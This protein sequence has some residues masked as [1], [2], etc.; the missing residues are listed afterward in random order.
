MSL[1]TLSPQ[2]SAV[3]RQAMTGSTDKAIARTLGLSPKTV[4]GHMAEALVK[5]GAANRTQ[6]A[7]M[8]AR[9]GW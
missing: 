1:N 7:V 3:L 2:Q 8:A 9:A 4:N 6:A 5:L